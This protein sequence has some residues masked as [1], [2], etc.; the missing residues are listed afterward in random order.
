VI[1]TLI[2]HYGFSAPVFVDNAEAVTKLINIPAQMIRLVV[3][4]EDRVL[5][6]A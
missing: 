4:A 2:E 1:S 3:S 6:V 5:R